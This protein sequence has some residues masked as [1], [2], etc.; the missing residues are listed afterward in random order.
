MRFRAGAHTDVGRVREGNED[1]FMADDPL[2]AVA[3]GMGGHQGGEVASRLAL[4]ALGRGAPRSPG[5]GDPSGRL[6]EVVRE[7][8][9]AVLEKAS[10][11]PALHGMGTTLTAVVA[12]DQ[13]I[14][15]AHVGDSRAYLLRDGQLRRLTKD[16]TV[17]ERMVEQGRLTP[18]E[19]EIHPQRSILTNALGVDADIRVDEAT[20]DIR[21][22]D[23]LLLCSDGLTGM[24]GEE[25][26]AAI[27]TDNADPQVAAEALVAAANEAG[28]QDNITALVLDAVED[29]ESSVAR[30]SATTREAPTPPGAA[31]AAP[32]R[33]DW[34]RIPAEPQRR[35][36][37][38]RIVLWVL[39]PLI[40][41]AAGLWAVKE[42]FVDNQWFVGI[43][44]E[45]GN[46]ALYR[47]IPA[48]PLGISLASVVEVSD[49]AAAEVRRFPAWRGLE[50][51]I[52]ADSREDAENIIRQMAADLEAQR[53]AEEPTP[54]EGAEEKPRDG[55]EEQNP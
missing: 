10:T 39:V 1:G 26:I 13:R 23:R 4:E 22:G 7:A 2:F 43:D 25:E 6:A 18:E 51:G 42:L 33:R 45:T 31:E 44:E 8:N 30:P 35:R 52:T 17:V 48:E 37:P 55:A 24:V 16:H 20:H 11:D 3:D 28:G 53:R 9:L 50:D 29:D 47:G 38:A 12:G 41:I 27:L 34:Q 36:I 46:V 15:L 40:V 49:I 54:R 5:D 21:P 32:R 14:H 19:A